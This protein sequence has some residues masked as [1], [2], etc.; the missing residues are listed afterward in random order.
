MTRFA[1]APWP[2]KAAYVGTLA[3]A[4]VGLLGAWATVIALAGLKRLSPD[5]DPTQI[6]SATDRAALP[7][8][9]VAAGGDLTL[10]YR[11]NRL[12]TGATIHVQT[13]S[14]LQNWTTLSST[15]TPSYTFQQVRLD[16]NNDPIMEIDVKPTGR[17][18]QFIRLN[19]T[20]P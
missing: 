13:S 4:G 5:I 3:A 15:S 20:S 19:V 16:A 10:T 12:L 2:L 7:V 1:S 8:F 6:M 18:G 17:A 11:Q 14:D 9:N